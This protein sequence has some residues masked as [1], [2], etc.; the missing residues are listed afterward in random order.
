MKWRDSG[1]RDGD[2]LALV[3]KVRTNAFRAALGLAVALAA[4]PA[5][6]PAGAG[7]SPLT[8]EY[9]YRISGQV[10][11]LLFWVSRDNI[12]AARASVRGGGVDDELALLI[13]SDPQR[14]PRGVNEWA[15]VREHVHDDV[16]LV[17][18]VR[19]GNLYGPPPDAATADGDRGPTASLNVMCSEVT[20]GEATTATATMTGPADLSYEHAGP[21]LER[22]AAEKA[23][24]VGSIPRP[25]GTAPGFLV[26]F[27]R[28][29]A[30]LAAR[31]DDRSA[32]ETYVYKDSIY[33]LTA[34]R[35]EAVRDLR[36]ARGVFHNLRR[37]TFSIRNRRTGDVTRFD[38][39][40]GVD[41]PLAGIPVQATYQP[42]WW[43]RI[44]LELDAE[45][46]GTP[47][48]DEDLQRGVNE[49]CAH[50]TQPAAGA[51]PTAGPAR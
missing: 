10:R 48:D 30:R 36:T 51:R 46:P 19:A 1:S 35:I 21:L 34:S 17:F 49:A 25:P 5:A 45:A 28:L 44:R 24:T 40:L 11:L 2:G 3:R 12:G 6:A 14:A 16:A 43:V 39:T 37:A 31:Q 47:S 32:P 4:W 22:V 15:F 7:P 50:A 9:R 26:A 8:A 18:T 33:D 23:W 38:A 20:A 27:S 29:T 42:N 41:G 13:G